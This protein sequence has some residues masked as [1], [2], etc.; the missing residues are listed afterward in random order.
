[1]APTSHTARLANGGARISAVTGAL[2]ISDGSL[3]VAALA[4]VSAWHNGAASIA[5][6]ER[7]HV[8]ERFRSERLAA[9]AAFLGA[10]RTAQRDGWLALGSRSGD[11][12]D[13]ADLDKVGPD[14]SPGRVQAKL[15]DL[16]APIRLLSPGL[17][18]QVNDVITGVTV[19]LVDVENRDRRLARQENPVAE[20]N[21]FEAAAAADLATPAQASHRAPLPWRYGAPKS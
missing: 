11:A 20:L 21:D 18:K 2:W 19:F 15:N 17:D 7:W 13:D 9:Y 1:M 4:V 10:A 5:S 12:V 8:A 16:A 6:A 3:V 14:V